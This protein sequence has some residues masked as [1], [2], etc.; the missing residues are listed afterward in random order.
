MEIMADAEERS[1]TLPMR[2]AYR[3]LATPSM[4]WVVAGISFGLLAI[5]AVLGPLETL[6]TLTLVQRFAYFGLAAAVHVP[7][8]FASGFFTLY[9]TRNC[10][11]AYVAAA[12]PVMCSVAVIPVTTLQIV[13][14]G[15]FHDG[16]SPH[17]TFLEIFITS[18]L[19]TSAGTAAVL[20]VIYSRVSRAIQ[21]N[22]AAEND[23]ED[24]AGAASVHSPPE[25]PIPELRLPEDIGRDIVYVHVSG[26]YVEVFT[27]GGT[28]LLLMSLSGVV[29]AL[30]DEGMQTHRSYW[31]AYRHI[32]RMESDG[33]RA[34]LHLT[35][36]HKVPVSRSFRDA[37][38]ADMERR[39]G[40][41]STRSG[42]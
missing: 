28:G 18:L 23:S 36:G 24:L 2:L 21:R 10:R 42:E 40:S 19:I 37:V 3:E 4:V 9:V 35:G 11:V 1:A 6:D 26:H 34:M 32:V 30:A 20:Y 7:I 16:R 8:C 41:S 12:V 13:L 27:T 33:R 29:R 15:A 14:Y 31:A 17:E 38:Q 5:V 25:V 39:S 22:S